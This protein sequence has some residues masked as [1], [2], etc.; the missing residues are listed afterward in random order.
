VLNVVKE[1]ILRDAKK[2]RTEKIHFD[3]SDP[4]MAQS[5]GNEHNDK[6]QDK[7]CCEAPK[8]QRCERH[9][10]KPKFGEKADERHACR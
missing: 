10:L 3:M 8:N 6:A 5:S 7:G 4:K 9:L 1:R 2:K